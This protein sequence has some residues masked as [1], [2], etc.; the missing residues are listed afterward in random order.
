MDRVNIDEFL[1]SAVLPP[2]SQKKVWHKSIFIKFIIHFFKWTKDKIT[3]FGQFNT[4]QNEHNK[5][6][7]KIN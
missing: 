4:T 7:G 1:S 3:R 2:D 5:S 6:D